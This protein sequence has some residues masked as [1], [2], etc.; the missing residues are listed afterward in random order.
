MSRPL[1][2]L[3]CRRCRIGRRVTRSRSLVGW[4][5]TCQATTRHRV[6]GVRARPP[7]RTPG[8]PV[9]ATWRALTTRPPRCPLCQPLR[10]PR[11]AALAALCLPGGDDGA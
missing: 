11:A 7:R 5:A 8:C 10:V 6:C 4:C 2:W 9:C 3:Q 1:R